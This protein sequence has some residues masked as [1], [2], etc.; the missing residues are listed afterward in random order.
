MI[1]FWFEPVT[2]PLW[3]LIVYG[4]SVTWSTMLVVWMLYA[5]SVKR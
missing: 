2:L 3:G 5:P 1:A 4:L